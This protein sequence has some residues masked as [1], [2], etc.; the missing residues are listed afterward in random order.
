MMEGCSVGCGHLNQLVADIHDEVMRPIEFRTDKDLIGV[1]IPDHLDRNHIPVHVDVGLKWT[2][3]PPSF[4]AR[5]PKLPEFFTKS[6]NVEHH[7]REGETWDEQ[8][9]GMARSVIAH[10]Q[11]RSPKKTPD[12]S[13][14][15]REVL[16]S[17]PPRSSD[18]QSHME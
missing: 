10:Y 12:Y 18:V 17:K 14:I 5:Y 13:A 2:W 8:F 3:I 1:S 16:R 9:A 6:F 4:E 15:M 11:G 7:I